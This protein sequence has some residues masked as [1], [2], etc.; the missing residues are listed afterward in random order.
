MLCFCH[1]QETSPFS[2][3]DKQLA[4]TQDKA[5]ISVTHTSGKLTKSPGIAGVGVRAKQHLS[6]LAVTL[7]SQS[8]M[9]H[10]WLKG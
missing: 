9:A 1:V 8:H 5:S 4:S 3:L 6:W 7:L 10:T 2:Y